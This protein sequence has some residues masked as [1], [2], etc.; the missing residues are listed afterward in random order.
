MT[1]SGPTRIFMYDI[2]ALQNRFYFGD[3]VVP[4][5]LTAVPIFKNKLKKM[6]KDQSVSLTA[7]SHS[8]LMLIHSDQHCFS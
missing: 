5:M 6:H 1:A 7:A 2:H 8:M 3:N 4:V